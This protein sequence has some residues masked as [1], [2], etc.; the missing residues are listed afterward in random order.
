MNRP[1]TIQRNLCGTL[2]IISNG[3]KTVRINDDCHGSY[4][5]EYFCF[6]S[7]DYDWKRGANGLN[8]SIHDTYEKAI[9]TAKR[10][11]NR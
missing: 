8:I 1:I 7:H 10:Y 4:M 5:N 6:G 11:L 9:S 2:T 3:Y